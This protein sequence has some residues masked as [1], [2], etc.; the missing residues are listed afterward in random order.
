MVGRGTWKGRNICKKTEGRG[1]RECTSGG[2]EMVGEGKYVCW[3]L[4][5]KSVCMGYTELKCVENNKL[6]VEKKALLL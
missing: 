1:A 2:S 3:N 5:K 4:I 6:I